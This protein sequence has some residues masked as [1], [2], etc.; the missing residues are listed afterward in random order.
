MR[1]MNFSSGGVRMLSFA[2]GFGR[3]WRCIYCEWKIYRK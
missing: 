2:F 3:Q 1:W